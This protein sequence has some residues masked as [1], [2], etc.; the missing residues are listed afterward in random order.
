MRQAPSQV[1]QTQWGEDIPSLLGLQAESGEMGERIGKKNESRVMGKVARCKLGGSN[2]E[3]G[4]VH[5]C[6]CA[7]VCVGIVPTPGTYR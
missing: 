1:P 2:S 7:H 3:K 6:V 4:R 5:V